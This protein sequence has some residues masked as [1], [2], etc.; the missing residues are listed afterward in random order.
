MDLGRNIKRIRLFEEMTQEE[1][2]E[3]VGISATTVSLIE[4]NKNK[5]IPSKKRL[6]AIAKALGTTSVMLLLGSLNEK[7]FEEAKIPKERWSDFKYH[8]DRLTG[9][10]DS[11]T[12]SN[13][14]DVCAH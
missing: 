14:S 12:I 10:M 2:A 7:D 3:K 4:N 11:R 1:L 5:T 13:V 6:E 8:L 9:I